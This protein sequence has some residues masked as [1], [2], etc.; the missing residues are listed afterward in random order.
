RRRVSRGLC[1][2]PS[3]GGARTPR[4]RSRWREKAAG[5]WH[6]P[7]P[8]AGRFWKRWPARLPHRLPSAWPPPGRPRRRGRR[9]ATPASRPGARNGGTSPPSAW[10][11]HLELDV[12]VGAAVFA[13]DDPVVPGIPLGGDDVLDRIPDQVVVA[14]DGGG[15]HRI[16][17]LRNGEVPVDRAE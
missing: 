14:L 10:L 8:G 11:S 7:P 15:D 9:A 16:D 12:A 17:L 1:G 2:L 6:S 4:R 13:L 3:P 5:W